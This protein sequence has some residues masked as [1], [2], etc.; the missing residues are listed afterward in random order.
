MGRGFIE[1][2]EDGLYYVHD[3]FDHAPDYV[4]K[5]AERE[6]AR[7]QSGRTLSGIRAEAGRKGGLSSSN[8]KQAEGS[9]KQAADVC[10]QMESKREAN[11]VTP[12]PSPTHTPSPS[13]TERDLF[14][15]SCPTPKASNGV[16]RYPVEF[17][18]FYSAYPRHE[19]KADALKAWK[20]TAKTRP[21]IGELLAAIERQ[22][23][24]D[25]WRKDGGKYIPLPASWL[26]AGR[27]A[28]EAGVVGV[29]VL[30]KVEPFRPSVDAAGRRYK[31]L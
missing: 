24:G 28:D 2:R 26:R 30:P 16:E 9:D 31:Q 1:E 15:V 18:E 27:W 8:F 5:R 13:L 6:A 10:L 22:K 11:E 21:P 7:T 25:G 23:A 20:T 3:F 4:R 12:S 19:A 17:L 14:E 29:S